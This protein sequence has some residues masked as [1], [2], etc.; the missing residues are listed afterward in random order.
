M[1]ARSHTVISL[2]K[3]KKIIIKESK[4]SYKMKN[5]DINIANKRLKNITK[6]YWKKHRINNH[7]DASY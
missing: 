2:L 7:Y 5:P 4:K 3:Q 1:R 6:I